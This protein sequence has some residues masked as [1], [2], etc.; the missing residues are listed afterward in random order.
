MRSAMGFAS[1]LLFLACLT[2]CR[3]AVEVQTLPTFRD[4]MRLGGPVR[5]KVFFTNM[6]DRDMLPAMVPYVKLVARFNVRDGIHDTLQSLAYRS[7]EFQPDVVLLYKGG[8]RRSGATSLYWGSGVTTHHDN[9]VH[10]AVAVVCRLAPSRLHYRLDD[11]GLVVDL[12]EGMRAA[13]LLE[14]DKLVSVDRVAANGKRKLVHPV[15]ERMLKWQ[16]GDELK[17]VWIRSEVGRQEGI[18]RTSENTDD[19]LGIVDSIVWD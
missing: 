11:E 7:M 15:H 12:D 14:G 4:A 1:T 10:S 2:S 13:G 3:Y 9:Y 17:V 6:I 16:V 5:P 18:A 19:Y 8:A